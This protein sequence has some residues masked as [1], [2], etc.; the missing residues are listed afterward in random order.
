[1]KLKSIM[2][3][4]LAAVVTLASCSKEDN[5]VNNPG[6]AERFMV[7]IS[8]PTETETRAVEGTSGTTGLTLVGGKILFSGGSGVIS[9]VVTIVA[10]AATPTADQVKLGDIT[11][12]Y[13]FEEINSNTTAVTFIGAHSSN[14]TITAGTTNISAVNDHVFTV[15]QI[16]GSVVANVPIYGTDTSLTTETISSKK[17]LVA[18]F[19][20][21]AIGSRIQIKGIK[22]DATVKSFTVEG[23]WINNYFPN[24]PYKQTLTAGNIVNNGSDVTKYV[25]P[26]GAPALADVASAM[27]SKVSDK[28]YVAGTNQFWAYNV[29]PNVGLDKA[30]LPHI[31][32][33]LGNLIDKNDGTHGTR[34]LTVTG[35][36]V[37]GTAITTM[38]GG[39]SY[40]FGGTDGL[41]FTIDD[42]TEKPEEKS[43]QG[44]V[45]IQAIAW[46]DNL[47]TPEF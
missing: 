17:T 1:M 23:I 10:D 28:E 15:A 3:A 6:D 38:T 47:V 7:K 11:T 9:K 29:I 45:T 32:I 8:V 26:Y 43:V 39:N 2:A 27:G 16:A 22:G 12:G 25:S 37:G 44:K 41:V 33:K 5:A 40:T 20:V 18:D 13:V 34:Y 19:S 35:Y 21:K 46:A 24:M 42:V 30:Q 14:P 4:A 31:I 36:K